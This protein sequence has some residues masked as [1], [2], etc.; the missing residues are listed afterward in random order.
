MDNFCTFCKLR[1]V[2]E[3]CKN[4]AKLI[5]LGT[6]RISFLVR[7]QPPHHTP[8]PSTPTARRPLLTEI[9][10]TP[11][12]TRRGD[13]RSVS[14]CHQSVVQSTSSSSEETWCASLVLVDG[15]SD[16]DRKASDC[17]KLVTR[18]EKSR[19]SEFNRRCPPVSS[20]SLLRSL[21]DIRRRPSRSCCRTSH[22][23]DDCR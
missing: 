9:L 3:P 10:N 18:R 21:I 1:S 14:A 4:A 12:V 15:T 2:T 19:G 16:V 5:V 11:L 7:G 23:G 20:R 8:H 22:I 6:K 13:W 17:E